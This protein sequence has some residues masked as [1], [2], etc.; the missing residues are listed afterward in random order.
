LSIVDRL[1]CGAMG[2]CCRCGQNPSTFWCTLAQNPGRLIP[3]AELIDNVW[4]NVIVTENSLVQCIKE[5]RE[6]LQ[7]DGQKA[8]ETVSKRGYLLRVPVVDMMATKQSLLAPPFQA[9]PLASNARSC[10]RPPL[11]RGAAFDNMSGIRSGLLRRWHVG[12]P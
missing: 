10:C 12:G 5:I 1:A 7:D 11:D 6:A 9:W 2:W 4:Q 8:I 3:K